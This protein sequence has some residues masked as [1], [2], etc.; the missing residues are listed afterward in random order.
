VFPNLK[1]M[2]TITSAGRELQVLNTTWAQYNAS[3]SEGGEVYTP[4]I[5]IV[6]YSLF[7]FIFVVVPVCVKMINYG[8]IHI[9]GS[10]ITERNADSCDNERNSADSNLMRQ[11]IANSMVRTDFGVG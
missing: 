6:L 5:S 2:N 10:T 8:S 4:T 7:L 1:K 9:L 11:L 3:E